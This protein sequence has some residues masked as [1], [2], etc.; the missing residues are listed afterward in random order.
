[1]T[2]H[3]RV[4]LYVLLKVKL[5]A[6]TD[7]VVSSINN[8]ELV[9]VSWELNHLTGA[10]EARGTPSLIIFGESSHDNIITLIQIEG[11][12]CKDTK[13]NFTGS[14]IRIAAEMGVEGHV[15]AEITI[16]DF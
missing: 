15:L 7:T 12:S 6:D 14:G 8:L 10:E 5:P 4:S 11:S 16:F 2:T 1:M 3:H 9:Y 13:G